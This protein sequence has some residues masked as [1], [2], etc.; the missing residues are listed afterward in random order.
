MLSLCR[1]VMRFFLLAIVLGIAL[2]SGCSGHTV[3][4]TGRT[5]GATAQNKFRLLH[6]PQP[7]IFSFGSRDYSGHWVYMQTGGSVDFGS[8]TAF[9]AGRSATL[10]GMMIGLPTGG[11]GS[12]VGVAQDVAS[13]RCTYAFSEWNLKGM[14]VCQDRLWANSTTCRLTEQQTALD[15]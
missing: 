8:A 10:N 12:Y 3:Y 2:L 9:S 4:L 5:T 7:V 13:L 14:G 1:R 11:N 15:Q 6:P